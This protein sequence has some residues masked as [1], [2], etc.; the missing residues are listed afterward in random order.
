[1][2]M[3]MLLSFRVSNFLSIKEEQ[4]FSFLGT[5]KPPRA[6]SRGEAWDESVGTLAG[7]FGANASGKSNALK[8]ISFMRDAISSSYKT[9]AAGDSIPVTPF[10]L[11]PEYAEEPSLFEAVFQDGGVRYQY[12]FRLTSREVVA[13]WLYVYA[14]HRRQ[15]WFERDISSADGWYFGKSFTGRNKV[16]RDLTKR[17]ALFLSTAVANNHKMAMEAEHF[18]RSHIRSAWPDQRPVG[19]AYTLDLASNED[20]WREV[21]EL[22]RFADLGIRDVRV[23]RKALDSKESQTM[24]RI[25]KAVDA[26]VKDERVNEIIELGSAKV[27]FGHSAEHGREPVY[28]P[29]SAESLGTQ[30]WFALV[31]PLLHAIRNG[32]TL[33]IDELD[34]SLHPNLTSEILGI[35]G[36]PKRNPRQAQLLFTSH[37]TTLLGGLAGGRELTREQV[38][39]TEKRTDGGTV[40]Y[41]LTDFS[42]RKT[43]NLERGYLQGRYGAVP[44]LNGQLIEEIAGSVLKNDDPDHDQ[45]SDEPDRVDEDS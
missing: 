36:D 27:E 34:S 44:Y 9:W 35:F 2:T 18:F 41:P 32:D 38:W 42:P 33:T 4:E 16:I 6:Q 20:R 12:G 29:L 22:M 1:M 11:S 26:N 39:F 25:L 45:D 43:E 37:D 7:I 14:T 19:T 24:V 15:V 17:T 40:L 10:A 8:A 3:A 23:S 30:A 28:L 31:G 13:E 5:S 21:V